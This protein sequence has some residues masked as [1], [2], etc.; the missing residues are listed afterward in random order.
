[1]DL[2]CICKPQEGPS[3]STKPPERLEENTEEFLVFKNET[4][5]TG[6]FGCLGG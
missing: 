1:M 4:A 2:Q 3:T 6:R 5:W